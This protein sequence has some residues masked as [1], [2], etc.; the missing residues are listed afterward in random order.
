MHKLSFSLLFILIIAVLLAACGREANEEQ[1]STPSADVVIP[2]Q[3]G[4]E[5]S[6]TPTAEATINPPLTAVAADTTPAAATPAAS[7]TAQ[8][9]IT[10][11]LTVQPQAAT[12]VSN[13]SCPAPATWRAYTVQNG[14]TLFRL[15]L[16]SDSTVN[17]LMTANCL[18]DGDQIIVGQTLYLPTTTSNPAVTPAAPAA[19]TPLYS[20]D[21]YDVYYESQCYY[22]PF[23]AHSGLG[24]NMVV[25]IQA[26]DGG[27]LPIFENSDSDTQTG[28]VTNG[29]QLEIT[30]GPTCL[31]PK[32]NPSIGYRRWWVR[33][34][35]DQYGWLNEY[36]FMQNGAPYY[37][38]RPTTAAAP[39]IVAFNTSAAEV[40]I[41]DNITINWNIENAQGAYLYVGGSEQQVAASG[42]QTYAVSELDKSPDNTLEFGLRP[43]TAEQYGSQPYIT[44]QVIITSAPNIQVNTFSVSP[45]TAPMNGTV[46]VS[47]NVAGDVQGSVFWTPRDWIMEN[48]AVIEGADS[49]TATLQLPGIFSPRTISLWLQDSNGLILQQAIQVEVTCPYT[50]FASLPALQAGTCPDA[51]AEQRTAAYQSFEHGFMVWRS[52]AY[53]NGDIVVFYDDGSGMWFP[54]QWAGEEITYAEA[55]PEGLLTPDRG[56]GKIWVENESVRDKLGWATA[57][58]QGYTMTY[59]AEQQLYSK[60]LTNTGDVYITLPNSRI[61]RYEREPESPLRTWGFIG[62]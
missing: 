53:G 42:S 14:D 30:G 17:E 4:S 20:T 19:S 13:S 39:R 41:E 61:I 2:T 50:Y 24:V 11:N 28:Q 6:R 62:S 8:A 21:L 47:W 54:D 1:L 27:A 52:D 33:L 43:I 44:R 29:T 40:K 25:E 59:Q 22:A 58:E 37:T 34:A 51:P 31:V 57:A 32:V 7:P 46:T 12:A 3:S 16:N 45:E 26:A 15:A 10:L 60:Y 48:I 5:S 36:I 38:L 23:A 56:F 55:P 9:T 49:G 18:T 35:D